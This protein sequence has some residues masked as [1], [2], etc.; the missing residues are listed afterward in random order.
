MIANLLMGVHITYVQEKVKKRK[1]LG[2]KFQNYGS[3]GTIMAMICA[4]LLWWQFDVDASTAKMFVGCYWLV[5]L[6]I[7]V[8]LHIYGHAFSVQRELNAYQKLDCRCFDDVRLLNGDWT[9]QKKFF[10]NLFGYTIN[11]NE[12]TEEVIYTK[13][14]KIKD[15]ELYCV[16]GTTVYGVKFAKIIEDVPVKEVSA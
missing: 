6:G 5:T 11:I 10:I 3:I 8:I 7:N 2:Q 13:S 9:V 16:T 4:F 12:E 14:G 1:E 15:N